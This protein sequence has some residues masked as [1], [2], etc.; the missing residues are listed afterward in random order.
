MF[1]GLHVGHALQ[2]HDLEVGFQDPAIAKEAIRSSVHFS[3]VRR[4]KSA[5]QNGCQESGEL[6]LS[7]C[8]LR[9]A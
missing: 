7:A 2:G 9:I 6:H 8:R 4:K 5:G 1:P 3:I